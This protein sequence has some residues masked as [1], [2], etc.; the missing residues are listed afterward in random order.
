MQSVLMFTILSHINK[1]YL[2][3]CTFL[4]FSM[5]HMAGSREGGAVDSMVLFKKQKQ[6]FVFLLMPFFAISDIYIYNVHNKN[7]FQNTGQRYTLRM[8]PHVVNS[9]CHS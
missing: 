5:H 3:K 2:L 9:H 4:L 7:V 1:Q 6:A 8:Q